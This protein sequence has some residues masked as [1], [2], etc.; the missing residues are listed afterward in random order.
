MPDYA[1]PVFEDKTRT[2]RDVGDGTLAE[3]VAAAGITTNPTATFTRPSDTTAYASGDL[4]A[5]STTAGSVVPMTFTVGRVS[6]GSFMLRRCKLATSS[7][8]T[9]SASFRL[10]LFRAAPAT[11]TNGDNG[12][13]SVSGVADY[14]GAFDITVDRAFTDG[15]AGVG[16]PVVGTEMSVKLASGTTIRGLLEARAAYTPTSAGTFTVTLDDLQ[17]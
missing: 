12:A 5:N 3:V 13:F 14:I 8:S 4:V 10:H 6:G 17:D 1:A 7:T 11:V 15:A 9:T 16:L 2:W